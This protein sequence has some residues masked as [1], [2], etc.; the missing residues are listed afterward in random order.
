MALCHFEGLFSTCQNQSK[1]FDLVEW[2]IFFFSRWKTL[3]IGEKNNMC[4]KLCWATSS[5]RKLQLRVIVCLWNCMMTMLY[6]IHSV[7]SG[8]HASEVAILTLETRSVLDNPKSSKM[9]SWKDYS[10]KTRRTCKIIGRNSGSSFQAFKIIGIHPK[11][12][13]LGVIRIEAE[14]RGEAILHV[15]NPACAL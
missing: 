10:M 12:G 14:R 3:K 8:L 7:R 11:A 15:R 2:F 9:Q 1:L 4:G 13:K 6:H 5:R